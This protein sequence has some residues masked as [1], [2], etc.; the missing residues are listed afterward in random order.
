MVSLRRMSLRRMVK[1]VPVHNSISCAYLQIINID[2][3]KLS[4]VQLLGIH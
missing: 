2:L 4:L 3:I 1:H